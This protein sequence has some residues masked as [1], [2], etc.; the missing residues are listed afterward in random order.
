MISLVTE[1]AARVL[2]RNQCF[3]EFS[4]D[5]SI[6]AL[7]SIE[8]A[9]SMS[10][11][12]DGETILIEWD[13][14]SLEFTA[15]TTPDASGLQLPLKGSDTLVA[16]V[17]NLAEAFAQNETL[18]NYFSVSRD[19]HDDEKV[20]LTQRQFSL[21]TITVTNGLSDVAETVTDVTTTGPDNL[22]ALVEVWKDT[23]DLGTDVRLASL[24]APYLLPAGTAAIDIHAAFA[25]V[26]AHLPPENTIVPG[27]VVSP[28]W[29]EAT[30]AQLKYYLRYADKYGTPA[31]SEALQRSASRYY[32]YHGSISA[33]S[34]ALATTPLRHNYQTR[35]S[36]I[37]TKPITTQQP[38]YMYW[39]CPTSGIG[40]G[41]YL[42]VECFWSDGT[43]SSYKPFG[44]TKLAVDA[45]VMYWFA[46]GYQA[47]NLGA[48]DPPVGSADGTY[49]VGYRA[50]L[51]TGSFL[52]GV[53]SVTY[54]MQYSYFSDLYLMFAN[55]MGGC[56]SVAFLGK[57]AEMFKA[58]SDEYQRPRAQGWTAKDGD[59]ALLAAAGR[60]GWNVNTGWYSDPAY[61][62]H[63]RQLPLAD[64]WIVDLEREKFLRV[65]VEPGEIEIRQDDETI[66]NL[67]FK[68]RAA[69]EDSDANV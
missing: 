45:N 31:I 16:Y 35:D 52:L 3:V 5:A 13:G 58:D 15:A 63:L 57:N 27:L 59:Y 6:P 66:Y 38:D 29:G 37:L 25:S 18:H 51:T 44:T 54:E 20:I 28:I 19:S 24:H 64:A 8:L 40:D 10:G 4:T 62:E 65:I 1:P 12:S 48:Q 60:R 53:H 11:P 61:L 68:I 43:S 56:E 67:S 34:K 32:C 7:A 41:V 39:V 49:L 50:N 36:Q 33:D 42:L 21:V 26:A 14:N 2:S 47:L 46:T 9:V 17:D 69:W 22:R 55:G 30:D 23:S